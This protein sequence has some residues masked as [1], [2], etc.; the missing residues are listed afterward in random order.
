MPIYT[1]IV[2]FAF[3]ASLG[4][5]GLSG[6]IAEA[7]VFLGAFGVYKYITA[8]AVT[9]I[10]LTAAYYLI[11]LQKVFLGKL[12]EKYKTLTE[13]NGREIFTLA[14]LMIIILFIGIYPMPVINLMKTS[15]N[16]LITLIP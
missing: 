11:A 9:G 4:L 7:M 16:H 12:P 14:P 2:S 5:P 10:I 3:F 8:F 15:L 1:A 13:I 6:F